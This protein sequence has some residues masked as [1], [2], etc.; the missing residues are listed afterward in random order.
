LN[1]FQFPVEFG[2]IGVTWN[3]LGQLSRIDWYNN[4]LAVWHRTA[5]PATVADLIDSLR[6]YFRQGEPLDAL[7]WDRFDQTQWTPFQR[8]V[9]R[10]ISAIPHGETRTY[11]WVSS[12]MGKFAASRAV[13]QALRKNPVP[14]LIP[15]H[16][17]VSATSLGGFMGSDDPTQPELQ[18]KKRLISLEEEYRNPIFPFLA[19]RAGA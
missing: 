3:S 4:R 14:I 15:C 8:E 9:Y 13:G 10:A 7:A 17:V 2:T 5:I 19:H 6:R 11:G 16:R 1:H 18:L 12:R